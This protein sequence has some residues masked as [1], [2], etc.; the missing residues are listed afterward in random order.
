MARFIVHI[1]DGK[2]GSS[3]IQKGLYDA[4]DCLRAAE[5][6]YETATPR[7]GHF[8]LVTLAGI[9]TRNP[10]GRATEQARASLQTIRDT[11]RPGDTVLLSGESFFNV[12]P[13]RMLEILR[14]ISPEIDRLDVIAYVRA[15]HSMYL[16]LVQ[17]TL[18]GD[19]R[20]TQPDQYARRIDR[21]LQGWQ[22]CAEVNS[23]TV[24]NFDRAHLV[25]G[26]AV[27]DFEAILRRLACSDSIHLPRSTENTS[28]SAEQLKVLQ[29]Y[30]RQFLK[31]HDGKA[32]RESQAILLYF[33][34]MTG[35]GFPGSRPMLTAPALASLKRGNAHIVARLNQSFPGLGLGLPDV[36]GGTRDDTLWLPDGLVEQ[37]LVQMDPKIVALVQNLVP[38]FQPRITED[39]VAALIRELRHLA[40]RYGLDHD[41]IAEAT[42]AFWRG[43][44]YTLRADLFENL[45]AGSACT[46]VGEF[47]ISPDRHVAPEAPPTAHPMILYG[48]GDWLFLKSD[49]NRVME[50]IAGTYRLPADFDRK[51]ADLFGLRAEMS[52]KLGYQYFYGIVPN[53][54]CV[55]AEELPEGLTVSEDRP[56]QQVLAAAA[57]QLD[58]RYYLEALRAVASTGEDVFVR[59]DTHWNHLGALIAFN[60]A[61]R[62]MGLPEMDISE[63]T[64]ETREIKAD[65]SIKMGQLC[66]T[67]VLTVTQPRFRMVDNNKVNNIGQRRIYEHEDK[68]LP[69]CVY[70]RD[71]FTSHQLE[72]FASRFS[73]IVY[74]W[75]PNIDYDILR[76]EA[77]DFVINQQVERF[78]VECPDDL[79]GPSH[80]EYER[81]KLA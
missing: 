59:G 48:K 58:H 65:L 78:L 76:E 41:R 71:S 29:Q 15:P 64:R 36:P 66:P 69:S 31:A 55:Y 25:D 44:K 61:M 30:R 17:Q 79:H 14:S 39:E 38:G 80:L 73:R 75:Q 50:Q 21:I 54:E 1:G 28:L 34:A 10:L 18:K 81:R 13:A 67:T 77:P 32:H 45:N 7:H 33:E 42:V 43:L 60:E 11:L 52:R 63:F 23:L 4:R 49:R 26:D 40:E 22:D 62:V 3:S 5:I 57:G 19:S 46:T 16:S 53:K 12:P 6:L 2:C 37:I 35:L 72:M 51:W 74:L 47:A 27:A 68:S 24:R 70:F 56:V 8:N 20:F 9:D